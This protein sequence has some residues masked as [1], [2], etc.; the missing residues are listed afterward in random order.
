MTDK[1][2]VEELASM[3]AMM[4]NEDA[5]TLRNAIAH[6]R[7]LEDSIERWKKEEA[8]IWVPLDKRAA[9]YRKGLEG[10]R[11]LIRKKVHKGGIAGGT[12]TRLLQIIT[13]AL[14]D[15]AEPSDGETS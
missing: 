9:R 12:V 6:I 11:S 5:Q 14:E 10:V 13:T 8:E 3:E 1:S 7:R 4:A 15:E 2:V